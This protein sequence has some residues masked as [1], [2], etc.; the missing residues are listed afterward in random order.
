MSDQKTAQQTFREQFKV[1]SNNAETIA[2]AW[3]DLATTTAEFTL[4]S[5][6]KSL[7]YSQEA[8]AQADRLT[9][10]AMASYRRIYQDGVN[11]WQSYFQSIGRVLNRSN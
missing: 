4:T 2:R 6:E 1:A 7:S 5:A 11:A 3:S 8:R 10:E 9:N